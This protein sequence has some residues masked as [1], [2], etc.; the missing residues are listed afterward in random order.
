M[1]FHTDAR[2]AKM[3]S[4]LDSRAFTIGRDIFFGAGEFDPA[5]ASGRQLLDHE[6]A[7][8]YLHNDTKQPAL[9]RQTQPGAA[10]EERAQTLTLTPDIPAPRVH[11]SRGSALATIYFGQ[12][13]F[14]IASP[15]AI[16]ILNRLAEELRFMA[17]PTVTVDGHASSE[18]STSHNQQLSDNRRQ[19]VIALLSQRLIEPI[20]F[21]GSAHGESQAAD[22]ET[23]SGEE[24]ERQRAL[25]RRVEIFIAP[26]RP[27]GGAAPEPS[28]PPNLFP[29][30]ELRPETPEE[31][32]E[33]ILREPPPS[34]LPRVS[35]SQIV[36]ERVDEAVDRALRRTGLSREWRERI[37][38]AARSA[39]SGAAERVL[40][41]V[42]DRA[43]LGSEEREA[44]KAAIRAT[45]QTPALPR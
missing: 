36:L 27:Q 28:R 9:L 12:D 31:R 20:T 24:L 13:D 45:I 29:R 21:G 19:A 8:A 16:R 7:H 39:V 41:E 38:S 15:S 4:A 34:P 35:L 5:S 17:N 42:L 32:L 23:G 33:R 40:D 6:L 18:G 22:G 30:F 44:I 25:N 26:Q 10:L 3:A 1:R 11:R 37:R 2:A 14:L 43:P